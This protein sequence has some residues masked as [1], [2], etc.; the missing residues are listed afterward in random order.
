MAVA[1]LLV[2]H[3]T[4]SVFFQSFFLHR[5]A[6]HRMFSVSKGWERAFYLMTYLTQGS[7]FLVPRGYAILHRMHHAYSDTPKDPHSPRN[8]S[9]VGRMMWATKNRYHGLAYRQV[10]PEARFDGDSPEWP[11]LDRLGQSW[12][13][14]LAWGASYGLF[15][16]AFATAWWQFLFL[17]LHWLMG[18]LHGSIV[19]WCGH[20]Y[21]YRTFDNGDDSRNTLVIDVVTMGELFQ[22]NHHK[23][24]QSPNFAVRWFELDPTWQVMRVL[25]WLGV[26][27]LSDKRQ[28]ARFEPEAAGVEG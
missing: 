14:R 10:E 17:P 1:L 18:P 27:R 20:R 2:V 13:A 4:L 8:F 21:G 24:P 26:I 6:A 28:V 16:I 25:A 11:A 9:G 3:S 7:S 19:N 23:F 22:N 15:Y 12:V 5:Y